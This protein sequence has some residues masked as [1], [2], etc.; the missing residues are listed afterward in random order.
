M[1]LRLTASV[2]M[3]IGEIMATKP[4]GTHSMACW[5]VMTLRATRYT[6]VRTSAMMPPQGRPTNASV[7]PK[8]PTK[9]PA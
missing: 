9:S 8:A 2:R 1:A 4:L 5:K 7:L 3:R 6:T